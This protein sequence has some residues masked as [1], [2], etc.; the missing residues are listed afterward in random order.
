MLSCREATSGQVRWQRQMPHR[1]SWIGRHAD[2]VLAAGADGIRALCVADGTLLWDW[3]ANEE[4]DG[5]R[6]ALSQFQQVNGRLFFFEAARRLVALDAE[7]G[8]PLWDR[9]APAARLRPL[10]PAGRF[11]PNYHAGS[12]RLLVQ[13]SSGQ[14]WLLDSATGKLLHD[15]S[16]NPAPWPQAPVALDAHRLCL[17]PDLTQA[18]MLDADTGTEIWRRSLRK[19]SLTGEAPRVF[20]DGKALVS[21]TDGWILERLRPESG[22]PLWSTGDIHWVAH[23][24]RAAGS[25]L[26]DSTAVYYAR[27]N[28][29]H[30]RALAD[31]KP[32]WELPLPASAGSW[33]MV[34]TSDYLLIYPDPNSARNQQPR[35]LGGF[36]LSFPG[37]ATFQSFP[38]LICDPK[39]GL[40]IQRLNFIRGDS[41]VG[42]QLRRNGL[43]VATAGKASGL[44]PREK[45]P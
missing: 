8:W 10:E 35:L 14:G 9:W 27:N 44:T 45:R 38:V 17:V 15:N 22:E 36:L 13:T 16:A 41:C 42:V 31:G 7:T 2:I 20:S 4:A 21:L 28:I 39:D 12:H 40:P 30:A 25:A 5:Q 1:P 43:V 32:L 11:W 6:P 33:Q 23:H 29:L 24:H 18:A 19:P 34:R 3:L 26:V 37:S